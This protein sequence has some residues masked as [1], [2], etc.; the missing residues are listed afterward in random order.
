MF[1]KLEALESRFKE[2]EIMI[3]DPE[4][5][6]DRKRYRDILQEHAHLS[7]IMECYG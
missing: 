5:L 1:E 6:R 2:L 3:A 7:K 4:L